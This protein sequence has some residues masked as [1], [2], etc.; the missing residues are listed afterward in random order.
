MPIELKK[1]ILVVGGAG[2]IGSQMV[3][4]LKE[5]GYQPLVLDNFSTGHRQV[6]NEV[7]VIEGELADRPLLDHI[8][9]SRPISAVMHFASCIEV[10]ES[11][12]NPAK[13]Y[14]NNVANTLCLLRALCQWEIKHFIFSSSAAVY[15]Q[16]QYTPIDE[17]HP[18]APINPYGRSKWMVEQMLEDFAHAEDL[19][20]VSLRYFNAAGADARGRTGEMHPNETHLIPLILQVASKQ[21]QAVSVYGRD[22]PTLDGTCIRDYIHV[23]DLCSAHLLALEALLAGGGSKI[24]NLGTGSGYSVKEVIEVAQE[25]TGQ[26]IKIEEAPRRPGDPAILLADPSLARKELGWQPQSSDLAKIIEDAWRFTIYQLGK[27]RVL[28]I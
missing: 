10:A 17:A 19:T 2:Y 23:D 21:R 1:T 20:Y 28:P 25:V 4:K 12:R 9:S 8:F 18:L 11:V 15:G 24:Y 26:Y 14:Q 5:Q 3:L 27:T 13:Y 22:Y 6:L 7:E 16:P